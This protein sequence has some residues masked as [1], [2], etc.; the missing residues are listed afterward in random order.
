MSTAQRRSG[1]I[2]AAPA[3]DWLAQLQGHWIDA[4]CAHLSRHPVVVRV[5]VIA[6]RGSA[7]REAG[8]TMLVDA[9]G[10]VGSAA[11][12][13]NGKPR[14]PPGNFSAPAMLRRCAS[15]TSFWDPTSGN[16]AEGVWSCGSSG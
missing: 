4:A 15:R 2:A 3:G 14:S 12:G 13:S 9:L 6:L 10:T 11:G 5:T 8:A 7:P 16:A 1:P